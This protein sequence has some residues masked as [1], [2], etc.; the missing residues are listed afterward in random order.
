MSQPDFALQA[1]R[2]SIASRAFPFP[3]SVRR[4]AAKSLAI[5]VLSRLPDGSGTVRV[6]AFGFADPAD[7]VAL[8]CPRFRACV[9]AAITTANALAHQGIEL[10]SAR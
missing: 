1:V 8:D 9:E 5:Q 4:I 3:V 10:V 7:L 2:R 6:H